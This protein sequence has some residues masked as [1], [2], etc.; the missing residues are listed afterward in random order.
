MVTGKIPDMTFLKQLLLSWFV[1]VGFVCPTMATTCDA[2]LLNAMRTYFK[3]TEGAETYKAVEEAAC[4]AHSKDTTIAVPYAGFSQSE[5]DQ[6]CSSHNEHFFEL[7]YK[8]V[9][10]SML[11][12]AAFAT[13]NNICGKASG[14]SLS[15]HKVGDNTVSVIAS[16]SGQDNTPYAY[17]DGLGWSPNIDSCKGGLVEKRWW[18]LAPKLGT[19]G[20]T[21][22]C[23]RK[24]GADGQG[25]VEFALQ[26][27]RATQLA[28]VYA[29]HTYQFVSYYGSPVV[30]CNLNDKHLTD[31]DFFSSL[32]WP[33]HQTLPLNSSLQSGVNIL[34][35][36]ETGVGV[37]EGHY[38]Y[39]YKYL[40]QEDDHEFR[41]AEI[42]DCKGE[43][44]QT[45]TQPDDIEIP[46]P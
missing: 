9:G 35:C 19:G 12:D 17:V 5:L 11:P 1:F 39:K 3:T 41:R 26:T 36:V 2:E 24:S 27:D 38:C 46:A 42:Y 14:L 6:A 32:N 44:K 43:T 16:W 22:Q 18:L 34:H 20:L 13:I 37:W 15:A 30:K 4:G 10:I 45:P 33:P 40:V 8:T 25:P 21:A 7:H 31:I 28:R 29:N 23:S